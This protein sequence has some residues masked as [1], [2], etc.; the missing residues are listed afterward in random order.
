M[1]LSVAGCDRVGLGYYAGKLRQEELVQAGPIPATIQRATQFHEFA[2]QLLGNAVG[3]FV[4]VPRMLSRPVAAREVA[5]LLV[6]IAAGPALGTA[7][8]IAGPQPLPMVD[9]VRQ[10]VRAR[11]LRKVVVPLTLPGAVGRAMAGGDL[12]PTGP[13]PRG[14]ETFDAWLARSR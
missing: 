2:A 13:G 3:P 7:P 6:P 1:T 10:V 5:A 12:L 14:T 9:L 4:P 11:G 8:E